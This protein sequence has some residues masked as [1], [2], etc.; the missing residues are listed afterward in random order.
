MESWQ[1]NILEGISPPGLDGLGGGDA[2]NGEGVGSTLNINSAI[3]NNMTSD[4]VDEPREGDVS[5]SQ[6][7]PFA[8]TGNTRVTF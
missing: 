1:K 4:G 5:P 8:W 3:S 2:S 7:I 6:N